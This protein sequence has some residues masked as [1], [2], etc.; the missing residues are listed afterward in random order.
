V[1]PSVGE[2]HS[3]GSKDRVHAYG[4]AEAWYRFREG[5]LREIAIAWCEEHAI[6]YTA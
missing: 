5:A 1:T 4:I 3:D 2:V 6:P